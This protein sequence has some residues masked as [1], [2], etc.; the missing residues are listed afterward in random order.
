LDDRAL[1]ANQR[2]SR[3]R[4]TGTIAVAWAET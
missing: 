2:Y 4:A 3:P 1:R